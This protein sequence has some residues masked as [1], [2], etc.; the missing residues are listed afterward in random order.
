MLKKI[1][2]VLAAGF[3]A[4]SGYGL[5]GSGLVLEYTFEDG[6]VS[7]TSAYGQVNSSVLEN[8]AT[9]VNDGAPQGQV[10]AL[11]SSNGMV[12]I[13]S[14]D[15][16]GT[17]RAVSVSLAFRPTETLGSGYQVLYEQGSSGSGNGLVLY[18]SDARIWAGI[19]S[20]TGASNEVDHLE[21]GWARVGQ[22][23]KVALVFDG[24]TSTAMAYLDSAPVGT[25]NLAY[26]QLEIPSNENAHIGCDGVDE[27]S[28]LTDGIN[29]PSSKRRNYFRG[30]IDEVHVFNRA[31]SAAEI[32]DLHYD[33]AFPTG[34]GE[35]RFLSEKWNDLPGSSLA[36]LTNR[37]DYPLGPDEAEFLQGSMEVASSGDAHGRRLSGLFCAPV[38]GYYTFRISGDAACELWLSEDTAPLH[39]SR[40]AFTENPM[41]P[42]Q[43]DAYATQTSAP[44]YLTGG[45][46]YYI[47][48]IH[49][50]D[51]ESNHMAVGFEADRYA[52]QLLSEDYLSPNLYPDDVSG[53]PKYFTF[54]QN[55]FG[56]PHENW[57][58]DGTI[59]WDFVGWSHVSSPNSGSFH[60][61]YLWDILSEYS[62]TYGY[63]MF[64]NGFE[65]A[66]A[67]N[68][69][70][71]YNYMEV[72]KARLLSY[73]TVAPK[74]VVLALEGDQWHGL[75]HWVKTY[76]ENDA[77]NMPVAMA[78]SRHPDV[79]EAG[80]PDNL[81]GFMQMFVYMRDKYAPDNVHI[82]AGDKIKKLKL[83][84]PSGQLEQQ[85][86]E[87]VA[88][89]QSLETDFD[90]YFYAMGAG[91]EREVT[92]EE[93]Y[94][95]QRY[96]GEMC[97]R[98]GWWAYNWRQDCKNLTNLAQDDFKNWAGDEIRLWTETYPVLEQYGIRGVQMGGD[99][100][101]VEPTLG[102]LGIAL[103]NHYASADFDGDGTIDRFDAD[104]DG[105]GVAD[106]LDRWPLN[107]Y[108]WIDSDGD[109]I[110]DNADIDHD[111]DGHRNAEDDFPLD[112][113]RWSVTPVPGQD[114]DGDGL[115]D[116]DE[117][118][119]HS[120][121]PLLPDSDDDGASDLFEVQTPGY[122]PNNPDV[123]N[124]G[125]DDGADAFPFDPAESRDSD[126][127]GLGDNAEVDDD[128]DGVPDLDDAFPTDP[129]ESV[130]SDGDGIGNEADP[131]DDNDGVND[132]RDLFPIDPTRWVP[133]GTATNLIPVF[134][135]TFI[136]SKAGAD[137]NYGAETAIALRTSATH[138]QGYLKFDIS[139][140]GHSVY[141]VKLHLYS[142]D[143][144]TFVEVTS[145][146]P[147]SWDEMSLTWNTAP[148]LEWWNL[149]GRGSASSSAE[150]ISI[151]LTESLNGALSNGLFSVSLRHVGG[152]VGALSSREGGNA[153]YLEIVNLLDSDGDQVHDQLDA[154]PNDPTEWLDTDDDGIGNNADLDDDGDG[155]LDIDDPFP[156]DPNLPRNTV[157]L[158]GLFTDNMMLQRDKE[159]PV[160]G[161]ASPGEIITVE[162][163]GQRLQTTTDASGEW[164]IALAPMTAGGPY[165]M[166]VS[167]NRALTLS[168][169]MLGDVWICGGQSNMDRFL[170]QISPPPDVEAIYDGYLAESNPDV[171]FMHI[172]TT[173]TNVPL[174]A[175]VVEPEFNDSWQEM[176][177]Y[178]NERITG[179]G[180]LFGRRLNADLNVPIG[181]IDANKSGSKVRFWREGG[182][183]FNGMIHPLGPSRSR[184]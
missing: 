159:V 172:A 142:T 174:D 99:K 112:P 123:D 32:D 103:S 184:A 76:Y 55:L 10:L 62:T 96:V 146:D 120:T 116:L 28:W 23:Q 148:P 39:A 114:S 12:T 53:L 108:E 153:P 4:V 176:S 69:V 64:H 95:E 25:L 33:V 163:N 117:L 84:V 101:H 119:L 78:D 20:S 115:S 90:I 30:A 173:P 111:N 83:D 65:D 134:E 167:G 87:N 60:R 57:D 180:F 71:I 125:V 37:T 128:N 80:V 126:G 81:S 171:R 122:N 169:I 77:R 63:Q 182:D 31:L 16:Q 175:I 170:T 121:N 27:R 19:Y 1:W 168:N 139:G 165:S 93:W 137:S 161:T 152:G 45:L 106:E 130:D 21:L 8:G 58:Y 56:S 113:R 158:H 74:T 100:D 34:E 127:D 22:W 70:P 40:I 44:I 61:D 131:D 43:W 88:Y 149:L 98:M 150:W 5:D 141:Q 36:T 59:P 105:D 179:T 51:G 155:L 49:K 143:E 102:A 177:P 133:A 17:I 166:T 3:L 24:A 144:N 129:T 154:F 48:A 46:R 73:A 13:N 18:L 136:V 162:F 54:G 14:P 157:Q 94:A 35:G 29:P 118:N 109:G 15:L 67:T 47:E 92:D 85:I 135:D 75:H 145:T 124:D 147:G 97:R 38:N 41:A 140:I 72:L 132:A 68:G 66:M 151:D 79:L 2:M 178:Y 9:I 156:T 6:A 42:E 11:G 89:Y 160:W 26:N 82:G 91:S 107:P 164:M 7:D 52:F 138:R 86:E 110:G 50:A 181:L 104:D 183:F